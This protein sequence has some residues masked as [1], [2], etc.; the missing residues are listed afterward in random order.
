MTKS[1]DRADT[2]EGSWGETGT[3]DSGSGLRSL[4]FFF[5]LFLA[6]SWLRELWGQ[7]S[8]W[9]RSHDLHCSC[10]SARSVTHCAGLGNKPASQRSE[11][12]PVLWRHNGNALGS[13][14][15]K[16]SLFCLGFYRS[17]VIYKVVVVCAVQKSDPVIHVHTII[18]S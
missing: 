16:L 18:L 8:D 15:K 17:R 6:I 14:L 12:P 13:F 7:G 1:W 3:S 2:Q 11:M 9:S 10:R 4:F 5:L